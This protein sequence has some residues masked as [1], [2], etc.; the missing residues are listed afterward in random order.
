MIYVFD[1]LNMGIKNANSMPPVLFT[2]LTGTS[3]SAEGVTEARNHE[4]FIIFFLEFRNIVA[5]GLD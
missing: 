5:G 3:R 1:Y 4:V 2:A